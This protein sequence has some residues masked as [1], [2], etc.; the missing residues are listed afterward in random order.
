MEGREEDEGED[1]DELVENS[2]V[3][4]NKLSQHTQNS[5]GHKTKWNDCSGF[6]HLKSCTSG[7]IMDNMGL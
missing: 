2:E 5:L 7:P 1:A 3:H 6:P 4:L